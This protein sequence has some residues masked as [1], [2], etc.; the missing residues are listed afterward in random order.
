MQ[1]YINIMNQN[2]V[3]VVSFAQGDVTGDGIADNIYL[4]GILNPGSPFIQ[5]ITLHVQDGHTGM[6]LSVQLAENAGYETT[7]FLGDFTGNGVND[8]FVSINSGGSGGIM[9]HYLYSFLNMIPRQLFD[10]NEYNEKYNY[11][12]TYKDN[13]KVEVISLFNDKKYI[14]DISLKDD[15]YLR[16]IYDQQGKLIRPI[17]GFVNPLSG[18]YPVDFDSNNRYELLAYQKIAGR[19][20][21]DSL[22]YVLNTLAWSNESFILQNQYV[23]I[24]AFNS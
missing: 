1:N 2:E 8:I 12:V 20:N 21:A 23:A 9:Y 4:T 10:F 15:D 17:E 24:F 13:Y 3:K 19:Y 6:F 22:G 16:E 18:L 7:I 5:N 14:I 11:K